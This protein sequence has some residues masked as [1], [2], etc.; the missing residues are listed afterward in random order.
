MSKILIEKWQCD[1]CGVVADK[2]PPPLE[3]SGRREL[4]SSVDYGDAG[5]TDINWRDLCD[6]CSRVVADDVKR[7]KAS[8]AE[9]RAKAEGRS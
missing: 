1:R 3:V 6:R 2:A 5:G 8:A 7:M 9:D 4:I